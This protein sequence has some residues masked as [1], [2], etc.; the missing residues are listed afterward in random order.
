MNK[1]AKM[2]E[3]LRVLKG[4]VLPWD[5]LPDKEPTDDEGRFPPPRPDPRESDQITGRV[6]Y[7]RSQLRTP[8]RIEPALTAVYLVKGWLDRGAASVVYGES[9]VGKTFFALDLAMHVAAGLP[10]HGCRVAEPAGSVLYI[11]S[12]GGH[13]VRNRISAIRQERIELSS[14]RFH[15]LPA[16]VDLHA[17]FDAPALATVTEG[18]GGTAGPHRDR[19]AHPRHGLRRREQDAGHDGRLCPFRRRAPGEDGRA[20]HGEAA[21]SEATLV[22]VRVSN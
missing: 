11:A 19:H 8:D 7:L 3:D 20:C 5:D 13:G 17:S 21:A 2:E 9:N 15:L 4:G 10:W 18:L 6:E 12:E 14:D 1:L 16:T 22:R